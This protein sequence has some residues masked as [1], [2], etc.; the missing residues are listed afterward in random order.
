[1]SVESKQI[2]IIASGVKCFVVKCLFQ[3]FFSVSNVFFSNALQLWNYK[4][5]FC[6]LL[7]REIII[8]IVSNCY[9]NKIEA[10][11]TSKSVKKFLFNNL[12]LV[13]IIILFYFF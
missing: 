12:F 7:S 2:T 1:M 11:K 9:I 6:K 10:N 5:V 4:T 3:L 8:Y 13:I